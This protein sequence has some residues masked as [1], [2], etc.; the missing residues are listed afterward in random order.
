M[1][2]SHE[3]PASNLAEEIA[4]EELMVGDSI[5]IRGTPHMQE[6]RLAFAFSDCHGRL[7]VEKVGPDGEK[8]LVLVLKPDL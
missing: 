2:D 8:R 4:N 3:E 6:L 1:S 5:V 7:W